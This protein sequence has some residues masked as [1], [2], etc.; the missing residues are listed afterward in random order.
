MSVAT[1]MIIRPIIYDLRNIK[2]KLYVPNTL[3]AHSKTCPTVRRPGRVC[4]GSVG[5]DN[6]PGKQM[7]SLKRAEKSGPCRYGFLPEEWFNFFHSKTGVT[8]P[9]VFGIVLTNYLLSKEIYVME[10][11]YYSG[12][13]IALVLYLA[14]TKLGPKIADELDNGVKA[15]IDEYEANRKEEMDLYDTIVKSSKDAQWRAEGQK[16]LMDAKKENIAMQ[17]EAVY[18][19]R[20]INVY[21]MVKGRMDYHVKKHKTESRIHQRWMVTWI[22]DNVQKAITPELQKQALDRAIQDLAAAAGKV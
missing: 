20:A 16:I 2:L 19:E 12:L 7:I 17:L 13:S 10:H 5:K 22:L 14:T 11:E 15:E 3:F 18:R 9:Y 6:G 21:R 4:P 1:T 8:G